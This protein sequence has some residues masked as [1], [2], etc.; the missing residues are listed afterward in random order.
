MTEDEL[1]DRLLHWAATWLGVP[2]GPF[3]Q[4]RDLLQSEHA[5]ATICS[6]C[7]GQGDAGYVSIEHRGDCLHVHAV[8]LLGG[9]YS[10]VYGRGKLIPWPP[11]GDT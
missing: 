5:T 6:L 7:G 4:M 9:F 1:K 10:G 8:R 3:I 11:K 2:S